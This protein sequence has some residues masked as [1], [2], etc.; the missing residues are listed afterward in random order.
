MTTNNKEEATVE[1]NRHGWSSGD[2]SA[3]RSVQDDEGEIDVVSNNTG[4]GM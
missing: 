1:D 4:I 3:D 2:T